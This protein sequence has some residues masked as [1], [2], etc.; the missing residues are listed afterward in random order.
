MNNRQVQLG[1][2]LALYSEHEASSKQKQRHIH[3][4]RVRVTTYV[5]CAFGQKQLQRSYESRTEGRREGGM[6]GGREEEREGGRREGEGETA[7]ILSYFPHLLITTSNSTGL[8]DSKPGISA[9]THCNQLLCLPW[10]CIQTP[11]AH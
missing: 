1:S 5:D 9:C 2:K 8:S 6:E 10:Q 11:C 4:V 7:A 3:Q